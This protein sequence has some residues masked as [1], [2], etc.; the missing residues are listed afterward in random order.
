MLAKARRELSVCAMFVVFFWAG[1]LPPEAL[2]QAAQAVW[3]AQYNGPPVNAA[4]TAHSMVV[5]SAGNIYVTGTATTADMSIMNRRAD[6]VTVKYD[7]A[8]NELW[9]ARYEGLGSSLWSSPLLAADSAGNV[10]VSMAG[11]VQETGTPTHYITVKYDSAGNQ[12]WAARSEYTGEVDVGALAVDAGGNVYITSRFSAYGSYAPGL[13]KYDPSGNQLWVAY[14][15]HGGTDLAVDST[16]NVY[17]TGGY[18]TVKCDPQGMELWSASHDYYGYSLAT[19]QAGHVYVTGTS[20]GIGPGDYVT[21]KYDSAGNELWTAVYDG[22]A[23]EE[24]KAYHLVVDSGGNVY[25]SGTSEADLTGMGYATIKYDSA[26]NQLWAA[27]CDDGHGRDPNALAVDSAGNVY[28]TSSGMTTINWDFATVKYN[29]AGTE[30]WVV[31]HDGPGHGRDTAYSMA[32]DPAGNVVVTG[33]VFVDPIPPSTHG[34]NDY[35]TVK[36]DADGNKL[37][38]SYKNNM[39]PGE[40]LAY[41]V[42]TDGDDNVYVTGRNSTIKYDAQGNQIWV[43]PDGGSSMAADP[44]GNVYVTNTEKGTLKY[45]PEGELL[46]A[47]PDN[48]RSLVLDALG[49]VCVV[50]FAD[51]PGTSRDFETRKY[52]S[53]GNTLWTVWYSNSDNGSY[54]TASLIDIDSVGNVYVAGQSGSEFAT[55]KYDP[56]G[57]ELWV[58]QYPGEPDSFGSGYPGA[59]AVDNAGFVYVT[60]SIHQLSYSDYATVKYDPAGNELWAAR[61]NGPE[62]LDDN[63]RAI[64]VDGA[65]NVYVAGDSASYL[66]YSIF[67]ITDYVTIKYDSAGNQLWEARYEGPLSL[68]LDYDAVSDMAVDSSG[69]VYVTGQSSMF[70]LNNSVYATLKYNT[71]GQLLWEVTY[72]GP[73]ARNDGAFYMGLK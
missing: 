57:N 30:L 42:I 4:D 25:V 43:T 48:G 61:Y 19:D 66:F 37:W 7:P 63:P 41:E 68:T 20:I 21:V 32:L 34:D 52:D 46:W 39:G 40:D 2:A 60:G 22:P 54:D 65:G 13:V 14:L 29:S 38:A 10:Y 49:N 33:G 62:D 56:D 24:D 47:V 6:W 23:H 55:V 53:Q 9:E 50:G 1:S 36:Y 5:D 18:G 28:M 17:V 69:N 71:N 16:G 27:R 70:L 3:T 64:A 67:Q 44:G 11:T 72:D 51:R 31:L 73:G 59:L 8:G 26:G 35:G 12:L 45:D 15:E 58:S